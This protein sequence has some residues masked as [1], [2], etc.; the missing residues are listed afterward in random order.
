MESENDGNAKTRAKKKLEKQKQ[1]APC[2]IHTIPGVWGELILF[3]NTKSKSRYKNRHEI[4]AP[5]GS[6]F[7]NG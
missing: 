5:R 2:T 3:Q 7:S 6:D 4:K 1:K